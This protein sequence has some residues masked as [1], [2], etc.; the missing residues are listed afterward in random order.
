MSWFKDVL[1]DTIATL[2]IIATVLIGHPILIWLVW[3]YTGLLL[4]VKLFVLVGGDFL[5][6][7]NKADTDAP[8][9]YN[10]LLYGT[11]TTV[12]CWFSWWY[13]GIAWAVIWII[14][15]ITQQKINSSHA[16]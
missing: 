8:E 13:L 5:N 11:N 15:F 7:M 4:L 3:G 2:T 16:N 1:V 14:S 10:H 12:L 9:W 6:L